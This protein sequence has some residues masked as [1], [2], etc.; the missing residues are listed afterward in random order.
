MP[1]DKHSRKL[2]A[3]GLPGYETRPKAVAED[4]GR[5]NPPIRYGFRSFDR[6]WIIPDNR[7]INQ[8]NPELW[9]SWSGDQ[10]Y[11]TAF[12]EE[13]PKNGPAL[14]LTGLIPDLHHYKGS[15]GGRVFPL[16]RDQGGKDSNFRPKLLAY[17]RNKFGSSVTTED[18]MAYIAAIAANPAFTARFQPDL[19]AWT[20]HS[21]HC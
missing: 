14:T 11:I 2:V 5:C 3:D 13:S 8:P 17:L 9:K 7:L 15:F 16:W 6:Q 1:G 19:S 12:T 20:A 4:T 18:L 10:I 21:S